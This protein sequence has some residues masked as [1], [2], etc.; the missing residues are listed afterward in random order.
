MDY[1][2][3]LLAVLASLLLMWL[4]WRRRNRQRLV[5]RLVASVAAGVSLILFF[6]PPTFQRPVDPGTAVLLTA[7]YNA[8]TLEALLGQKQAEQLV[9]SYGTKASDATPVSDLYTWRQEHLSLTKVH[10]L[11]YGLEAQELEALEGIRLVPHLSAAPTGVTAAH[12]P[13]SVRTGESVEI[14]GKYT[15][16]NDQ[17]LWLYLQAAGQ[18]QDSVEIKNTGNHTFKL[19]YSPKQQGRFTYHILSKAGA[20]T[21]TLGAVPV[22]VKPAQ[23]LGVLLLAS[24]PLFEFK[25]LKNHL[26]EQ[27]HRVALHT[28]VSK[29]ISQDEWVN[30]PKVALNRITPKL[31][32]QFDVVI[33][34]PQVLQELSTAERA[35]L[36][37]AVTE[38]GLGILTV[39]TAPVNSRN[40]AFF[41]SFQTKRLSQQE[42]RNVQATWADGA[43]ETATATALP[44]T[45][46]STAAVTGIIGE[47]GHNILVGAKKAGWG[48]VAITMVPQT[49]PW[50][51]EGKEQVYASYWANLLTAIARPEVQDK[52]WQLTS[53]QVPQ[54]NKP[55]ILTYTNY[56]SGFTSDAIPTATVSSTID[57]TNTTVPLQQ[58]LMQPE[59]FSGTFWPQRTGWHHIQTPPHAPPFYFYVQ[60]STDWSFASI[61]EKRQAT[62]THI[63]KQNL[64]SSH[65]TVT[66][67]EEQ[68]PAI[69]FFA[70]FVMASG[71]LW[72]EEKL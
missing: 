66:Y 47:Q 53:P 23:E 34:E 19:K 49:F 46:A 35:S 22:Q 31:L 13:S 59:Q 17:A 72:L 3:W 10:I 36:E 28:K 57:S 16:D 29:D 44:Y 27:Q 20:K 42:S 62:Q 8:D 9:F 2:P 55:A 6:S 14:A 18:K 38:E 5:W 56:S 24:S 33:T 61:Q 25:F 60:D 1:L 65:E 68:V 4:A 54:P 7:G 12:W 52:F 26:A 32:Q 30:M 63:A 71:F 48:K 43:S 21:D 67:E 70:L 11:G 64:V 37:R 58:N 39:A 45:I 15:T 41:T 51:L 69:W 50:L 40:T